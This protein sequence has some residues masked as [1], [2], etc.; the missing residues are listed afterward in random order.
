MKKQSIPPR[1]QKPEFETDVANLITDLQQ[2]G[3]ESFYLHVNSNLLSYLKPAL[4][5]SKSFAKLPMIRKRELFNQYY[6]LQKVLELLERFVN[7]HPRLSEPR[8]NSFKT[9]ISSLIDSLQKIGVEEF[10]FEV[11]FDLLVFAMAELIASKAF[12]YLPKKIK[13]DLF[14]QYTE[15]QSVLRL[16]EDFTSDHLPL[17]KSGIVCYL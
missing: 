8:I 16:L 14:S 1:L 13:K 12:A 9:D 7:D 2:F 10:F 15:L 3:I 17:S 4:I 11:N 6:K 5:A